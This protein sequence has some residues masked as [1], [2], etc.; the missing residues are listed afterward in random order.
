MA[1]R[2]STGRRRLRS[3]SERLASVS[4]QARP[5]RTSKRRVG[6]AK[7]KVGFAVVGL[8]QIAQLQVLPAF[9]HAERNARLVALVSSHEEK[10]RKLGRRYKLKNLYA[11]DDFEACLALPEV[12]A[13]YIAT[14]NTR[15]LEFAERAA[16][17]GKHVLCEKPMEID[18]DRCRRMIRACEDAGVKLMIAYRLHFDPANLHAVDLVTKGKI[19]E[20]KFFTSDFSQ[21]VEEGDIRLR[22]ETGGGTLWDIG[23]YCINASR[24]LFQ[25]DPIEAFARTTRGHEKRFGEVEETASCVLRFPEDRVASFTCSFGAAVTSSYRVVGTK[26]DLRLDMAYAYS[27]PREMVI[28]VNGRSTTR[29]WGEFDQFAPELEHFSECVLENRDPEPDG[30]EGLADVRIISALYESARLGR[31]VRIQPVVRERRPE[32]SQA[33]AKPK[34][35]EPELVK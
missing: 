10:L 16:R 26:G 19:G 23:I 33:V 17:A 32:P 9:A 25:D 34:I 22:E 20:P 27:E 4:K 6:V 29:T 8:G 28:T 11:Y 31:P 5:L 14:P 2:D 30:Y 12:D 1:E 35:H 13:V 7:R 15:H 18:E 21:Q 24:Y 3:T